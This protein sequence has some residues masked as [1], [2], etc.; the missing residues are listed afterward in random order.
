MASDGIE[1]VDELLE[2]RFRGSDVT[3]ADELGLSESSSSVI[4]NVVGGTLDR[5][6]SL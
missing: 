5:E 6:R 2:R 1:V 4:A 3:G